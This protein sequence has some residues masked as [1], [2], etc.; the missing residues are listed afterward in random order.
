MVNFLPIFIPNKSELKALVR[1]LI[2][3]RAICSW[4]IEH[5]EALEKLKTLLASAPVLKYDDNNKHMV[6]QADASQSGLGACPQ[7][8]QPMTYMSR[9]ITSAEQNY[10]QL[11]K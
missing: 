11:E 7:D 2:K 8:R 10:S 6:I 5:S 3:D 1:E 4:Q 9:A